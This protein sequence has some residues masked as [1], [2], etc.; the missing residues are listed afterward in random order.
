VSESLE[1]PD[2]PAG[3]HRGG[4]RDRRVGLLAGGPHRRPLEALLTGSDWSRQV[5]ERLNRECFCTGLDDQGL[6]RALASSGLDAPV[7][8]AWPHAFAAWPVFVSGAD[9]DRMA[10]VVRAVESVVAL[11][12]YREAV[13]SMAPSIARHH[14]QG[15]HGV[16]LGYDFHLDRGRLSL[17]EINTNAG[18]AMLNAVAAR[19][20]RSCC[21]AVER[22]LPP[23]PSVEAVEGGIVAMFRNEWRLAGRDAPLRSIAIVDSDP[24]SQYLYPEFVLFQRLFARHGLQAVICDPLALRLDNGRLWADDVRIDLVYQ[25]STDFNLE[26]DE[27]ALLREAYLADAIVLTPH[28]RRH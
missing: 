17:I 11:P 15:A 21:D 8:E 1:A 23:S 22:L 27:S 5:T 26:A 13:L 9:M 6:T 3:E 4:A 2:R 18:G 16:F 19:A 28:L 20:Q 14:P 10:A 12:A 25:R 7:R 24:P